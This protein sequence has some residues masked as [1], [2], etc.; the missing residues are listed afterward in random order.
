MTREAIERLLDAAIWAPSAMN[1]QP[2]SFVVI[3]DPDL[4][5]RYEVEASQLFLEDPPVGELAELP[6]DQ[7]EL[8]RGLAA[9][10]G[11]GIFHEAPALIVI[12]ANREA[13]IADCFLAAENLLLAATTLG[14][15]S[16]PIGMA[17]PYFDQA[18]VKRDLGVPTEG[19]LRP[20]HRRGRAGGSRRPHRPG[21]APHRR[22]EMRTS[23]RQLSW[24][25]GPCRRRACPARTHRR[26]PVAQV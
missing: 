26:V 10:P 5:E 16:C 2:W 13:D 20:G 9:A 22:L 24:D 6:T 17:R 14:L 25:L 7:L 19:L 21:A 23:P 1:L 8:L 18:A 11:F 4:L 12:Y 15:G 3:Q